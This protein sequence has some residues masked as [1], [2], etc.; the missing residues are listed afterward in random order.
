[1]LL[2]ISS[3]PYGITRQTTDACPYGRTRQT[4]TRLITNHR[5]GDGA[6]QCTPFRIRGLLPGT[7]GS[8]TGQQGRNHQKSKNPF[9]RKIL[10]GTAA[11]LAVDIVV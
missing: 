3:T 6:Q 11:P 9:H 2:F 5:T 4:T 7:Q 10:W 1:M 8:T